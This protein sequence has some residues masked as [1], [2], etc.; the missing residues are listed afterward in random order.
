[1]EIVNNKPKYCNIVGEALPLAPP[2]LQQ[3]PNGIR[4][5]SAV[6][7]R[8]TKHNS[9][10]SLP[11]YHT[12]KSQWRTQGTSSSPKVL[13]C[14]TVVTNTFPTALASTCGPAFYK[15]WGQS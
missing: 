8:K 5:N 15:A 11:P 10:N 9:R 3:T 14:L 13:H 2:G 4:S 6:T 12:G 7:L 1:M